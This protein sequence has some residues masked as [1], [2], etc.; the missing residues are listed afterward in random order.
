MRLARL[1]HLSLVGSDR[2]VG[3]RMEAGS[4]L[5]TADPVRNQPGQFVLVASIPLGRR[6]TLT[7]DGLRVPVAPRREAEAQIEAAADTMAVTLGRQR[8][9]S[10]P[11]PYI[12]LMPET[13]AELDWMEGTPGFAPLLLEHSHPYGR[14]TGRST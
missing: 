9:L 3:F 2:S 12:G 1:A 13:Q 10:S 14:S 5:V 8:S 6:P 7:V 4:V 11:N